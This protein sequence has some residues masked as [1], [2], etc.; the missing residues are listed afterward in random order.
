MIQSVRLS[1]DLSTRFSIHRMNLGDHFVLIHSEWCL[2]YR[3]IAAGS[4]AK[5]ELLLFGRVLFENERLWFDFE[6]SPPVF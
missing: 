6:K 1:T 2:S 3:R 4:A 5:I